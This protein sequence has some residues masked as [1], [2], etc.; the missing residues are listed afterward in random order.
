MRKVSLSAQNLSIGYNETRHSK[1][2]L[3]YSNLNF[4]LYAGELTCLLGPNGAGKSTLLRTLSG[5]QFPLE[6]EIQVQGKDISTYKEQDLSTIFGLVLT[7]K[8]AAGGLTVRELV[9]LGRYPY[10]GFFGRLSSY[11]EQVIEKAMTDTG[12]THKATSYVSELS[13]GERQKAMIAK[14]LAQE[15]P[16]VLLDEP[17]AFL[18]ATSRIEVMNLLY[19]LAVD[20]NKSIL[21]STHDIELALLLADRLWLLSR[22]NGLKCGLTEDI[23]LSGAMQEFFGQPHIRFDEYTGSFMPLRRSD[24]AIY[25]SAEEPLRRWTRN[26]LERKGYR[27]TEDLSEAM[28]EISVKSRNDIQVQKNGILEHLQ[29]FEEL[30]DFLDTTLNQD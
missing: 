3:L 22:T 25:L 2:K 23:V 24:R 14:A 29:S 10:T 13:D 12:I 11:D 30:V 4:N 7:D 17:T 18:D 9:G 27:L 8:L 26:L 6:G 15:C 16:I 21:L 1:K 28:C 5:S 20:H 19:H